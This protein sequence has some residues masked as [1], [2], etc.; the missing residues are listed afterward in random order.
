LNIKKKDPK[1]VAVKEVVLPFIRF[2]EVDPLLG[3]EMR[4]TGEVMGR[5]IDFGRSFAK[6]QLSA[7]GKNLP[8]KGCVFLS[9]KDKDKPSIVPIARRLK[10]LRFKLLATEGTAKKLNENGIRVKRVY[11]VGEGRPNIVDYIK[12]N[13]VQLIINTP[14]GK[15]SKYDESAIRKNAVIYNIPY[16]TTIQAASAMV[17]AIEAIRNKNFMIEPI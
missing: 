12:N 11:K 16:I 17:S 7:Y 1:F 15:W 8:Q 5:D 10:Q 6:S 9:V 2:P 14:L 13:Q 3:P 4:S